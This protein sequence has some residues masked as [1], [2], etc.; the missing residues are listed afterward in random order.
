MF[1]GGGD[2]SGTGFSLLGLEVAVR[3]D[4]GGVVDGTEK[5]L[6]DTLTSRSRILI[7]S[8][9]RPTIFLLVDAKARQRE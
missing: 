4:V 1:M 7:N 3:R 8:Q 2:S 5:K 6:D 9:W